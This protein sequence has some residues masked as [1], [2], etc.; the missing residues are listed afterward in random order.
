M[1]ST[2][3][4]W[5]L[6]P[7]STRYEK[8]VPPRPQAC[9]ALKIYLVASSS[10]VRVFF[11]CRNARKQTKRVKKLS[12]AGA[13]TIDTT[14]IDYPRWSRPSSSVEARGLPGRFSSILEALAYKL[15]PDVRHLRTMYLLIF[16]EL[17]SA[18]T[19]TV[20]QSNQDLI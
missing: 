5:A 11:F 18:A 19:I 15:T 14:G 2:S 9:L 3:S 10:K 20:E 8:N 4:E 7:K 16:R 17:K 1:S 13:V 12:V 6:T